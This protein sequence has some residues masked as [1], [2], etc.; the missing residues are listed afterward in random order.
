MDFPIHL[1]PFREGADIVATKAGELFLLR[2]GEAI[3]GPILD[4]SD[5]VHNRGERGLLGVAADGA[6]R[7]FVHYSANG[8][9]TTV[10]RF[11]WDGT[12]LID[13]QV[14]FTLDQPASNHNGGMVQLGPD[15]ALYLGLGDGGGSNDRFGNGQDTTTLLGGLV[16]IDPD[17]GDAELFQYGLRNPWRFWIEDEII[18]VADVGQN[19]FEEISVAPLQRDVNYG[20]PITEGIHCFRPPSG[21]DSSGLT[22][23]VIEV[24]HTDSGTCS[25][26]GGVVYRGDDIP[27]VDGH[28][29]YSDFCG[30][31]LRSIF[32]EDGVLQEEFDWTDQVGV[33]GSVASFGV[34]GDGSLY[35]LTTNRILEVVAQRDG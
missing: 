13:E 29:F 31:Y 34:G 18:Y 23:P 25:I 14:L 32:Y 1:V 16:R 2:D 17:S 33:A 21:C 24:P 9:D 22:L 5:Q 15:G 30:G 12:S 19:A 26:T 20:W 3:E 8:G 35:V 4:I 6:D 7:V 28:F 11:T 27:E 10:S